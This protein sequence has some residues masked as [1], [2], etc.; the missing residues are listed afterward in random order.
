MVI[1]VVGKE[2][3]VIVKE[4]VV[5][6]LVEMMQWAGHLALLPPLEMMILGWVVRD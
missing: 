6:I 4:D 1:D 5:A 3:A 2:C